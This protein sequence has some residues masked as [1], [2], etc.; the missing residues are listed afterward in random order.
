MRSRKKEDPYTV[1]ILRCEGGTLYTGIAKDVARRFA[2]HK[3]GTGARYTRAH[4]PRALVY[5]ETCATRGEALRR[6]H[7][8]KSLTRAEKLA[9]IRLER[10]KGRATL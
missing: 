6:E 8:I 4:P 5:R 2:Q 3:R 10:S 7:A 9:L 1:Y